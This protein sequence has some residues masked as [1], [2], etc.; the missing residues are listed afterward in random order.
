MSGAGTRR[1]LEVPILPAIARLAAPG[2]VLALF[3]TAVSMADTHFVGRLGT[4]ALAGLALAFPL[5]MLLQNDA[6][7]RGGRRSILR[8]GPR[9]GRRPSGGRAPP[10]G[11]R[12]RS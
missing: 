3:P 1:L 5:V 7:G 4:D 6:G 10:S 9:A 12:A 2:P 11:P 8:R